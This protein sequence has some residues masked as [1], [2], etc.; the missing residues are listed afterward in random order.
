[1]HLQK[2]A[3]NAPE[4]SAKNVAP[5][6]PAAQT[7]AQAA[8][9]ASTPVPPVPRSVS[10]MIA[11]AGLPAD[12]LSASIISFARFFSLPLK[13]E[14]MSAIR[15]QVLA[16][17]SPSSATATAELIKHAATENAPNATAAKIKEAISLA[18]AAAESKGV[19]L[20]P[21]GLEAFAE[22]IDP[23]W[24][25][26]Q[27]GEDRKQ[28]RRNKNGER[29]EEKAP[30]KT[31]A[32][33]AGTL[34]E[35]A[36]E[37]ASKDSLLAIMNKL[38][39]KDGHRWIVLPFSFSENDRDFKV[40]LRIL[41]EAEQALNR[42]ICMA[43]DIAEYG[44]AENCGERRWLFVLEAA[45]DSAQR[46]TVHTKPELPQKASALFIRELSCLLNI[47]IER[48]CVK[49]L[50]GNNPEE[51]FPCESGSGDLLRAIDEAV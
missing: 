30:Q 48:V 50:T 19:E 33:T 34:K 4:L 10:A 12:K 44:G 23:D 40:S 18:A 6:T 24:R 11:A 41:L 14:M 47:P 7:Q 36:L 37:A 26:R 43:I 45:N 39:G 32:V 31:A 25:K 22:A 3:A 35:M 38:P 15:R 8:K 46:L 51:S 5:K 49:S 42:A 2:T 20:Q 29:D 28:E 1:M 21:K 27:E 16:Q 9:T 17:P 13:S